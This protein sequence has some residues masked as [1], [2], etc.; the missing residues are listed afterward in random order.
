LQSFT[1]KANGWLRLFLI[2]GKAFSFD[3]ALENV[4]GRHILE[5][6]ENIIISWK[7]LFW[8]LL[9]TSWV[10]VSMP[11]LQKGTMKRLPDFS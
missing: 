2:L 6:L 3:P 4:M 8:S 7:V 10:Y 5:F 9:R 1:A 11:V